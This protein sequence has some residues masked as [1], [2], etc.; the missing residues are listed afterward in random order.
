MNLEKL[1][2]WV[3]CSGELNALIYP[4]EIVVAYVSVKCYHGEGTVAEDAAAD[5]VAEKV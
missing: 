5:L 1:F 2:S 3:L 4:L